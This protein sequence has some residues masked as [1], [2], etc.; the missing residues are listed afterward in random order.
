MNSLYQF[1][2]FVFFS[3]RGYLIFLLMMVGLVCLVWSGCGKS[4]LINYRQIR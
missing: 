1:F 4:N 2:V 3:I